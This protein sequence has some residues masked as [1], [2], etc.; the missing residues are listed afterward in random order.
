ME[1][2]AEDNGLLSLPDETLFQISESLDVKSTISYFQASKRLNALLKSSDL[3][4]RHRLRAFGV[5]SG[6]DLGGVSNEEYFTRLVY[7]HRRLLGLWRSAQ[8]PFGCLLLVHLLPGGAA[9]QGSLVFSWRLTGPTLLKPLFSIPLPRGEGRASQHVAT[10][11]AEAGGGNGG[12]G[13][14]DTAVAGE[15]QALAMATRC[16]CHRSPSIESRVRGVH[17]GEVTAETA[18]AGAA[19]GSGDSGSGS[20]SSSG[21]DTLLLTCTGSC[22]QV[23]EEMVLRHSWTWQNDPRT[24]LM[25]LDAA[26]GRISV[27]PHPHP[28][29]ARQGAP[30]DFVYYL[31]TARRIARNWWQ[32]QQPTPG[33]P[34]A[35]RFHRLPPPAAAPPPPDAP[36][37]SASAAA[38]AGVMLQGMWKGSYGLHGL[39]ILDLTFDPHFAGGGSGG[40]GGDDGV[41][42]GGAPVLMATK[43]TGDFNVPA[44]ETTFRVLLSQPGT[45]LG[46][47]VGQTLQLPAGV[48]LRE[49]LAQEEAEPGGALPPLVV[50][51]TFR[52]V[53]R[54]TVYPGSPLQSGEGDGGGG[55]RWGHEGM[56]LE[57]RLVARP[58][59]VRAA[60]L[61]RSK[62]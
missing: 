24:P 49:E 29:E 61:Y 14:G 15:S 41:E 36:A 35:A 32:A 44:G 26:T 43:L 60:V 40:G 52:S 27:V 56:A 22:L 1:L 7:P 31:F 18:A 37:S 5:T 58:P 39:E 46:G 9:L 8:W 48:E 2:D 38:S 62:G 51:Q 19:T 30:A 34:S 20:S 57:P 21:A 28:Q 13:G 25:A 59:P 54:G 11:A 12:A 4:W 33:G 17:Y 45:Q 55:P 47:Q 53:L 42:A 16:W 10:A 50:R 23:D 3:F 6:Q